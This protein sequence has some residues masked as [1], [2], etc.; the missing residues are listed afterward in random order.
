MGNDKELLSKVDCIKQELAPILAPQGTEFEQSFGH[1]NK[2]VATNTYPII[3]PAQCS[4]FEISSR[5]G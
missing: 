2:A 4:Q 3:F 5:D 1:S